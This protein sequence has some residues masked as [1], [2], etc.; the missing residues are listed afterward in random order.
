M[1]RLVTPTPRLLMLL[2]LLAVLTFVLTLTGC[3]GSDADYNDDVRALDNPPAEP[4]TPTP[5]TPTFPTPGTPVPVVQKPIPPT[6]PPPQGGNGDN[7]ANPPNETPVPPVR[8]TVRPPEESCGIHHVS[9]LRGG[10]IPACPPLVDRGPNGQ[11][12]VHADH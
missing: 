6:N 12:R 7:H 2:L 3:G 9:A 1:K 10:A 8:Q 11:V 4:G 5:S